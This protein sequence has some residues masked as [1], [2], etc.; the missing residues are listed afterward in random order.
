MAARPVRTKVT[1]E[2]Q[3]R[4]YIARF[5]PAIQAR[6]RAVRSS[7]RKRMPTANELVYDYRDSVVIG[8]SPTEHGIASVLAVSARTEGV[9]LY[10]N[11][12][13]L[14]PDPK[15]LLQGSATQVRFIRMESAKLVAHPDVEAL[16]VAALKRASIPLA[17][18]GKGTLVLKSDGA[19][20][21]AR[22]KK[23][24]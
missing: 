1:P 8:Y 21:A 16:I 23:A 7:V 11:Q 20:R 24:K 18:T 15:K 2:A 14:L 10:F 6:F 3:L 5:D 12:G 17:A 4:A 13:K 22:K 9:D 19:K